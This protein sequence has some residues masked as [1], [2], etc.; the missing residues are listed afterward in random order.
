M[1]CHAARKTHVADSSTALRVMQLV[2]RVASRGTTVLCSVHQPRPEVVSLLDKVILLSRG[3]V[4]FSGPPGHAEAYFASIGRP[5]LLLPGESSGGGAGGVNPTDSMLDALGETEAA[6]D[7]GRGGVCGV[8][9]GG[10]EGR[11]EGNASNGDLVVM[12]REL[13]V[14]QVRRCLTDTR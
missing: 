7:R 5:F 11:G 12:P 9:E 8:G 2:S 1:P 14:E 3:A 13:L 10:G 4:A 6:A